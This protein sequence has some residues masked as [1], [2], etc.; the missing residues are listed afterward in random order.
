[1]ADTAKDE[2]KSKRPVSVTWLGDGSDAETNEWNGRTFKKG[3]AVDIDD[4]SMVE[5]AKHNRFYKVAGNA[6]KTIEDNPV[7]AILPGRPDDLPENAAFAPQE[8]LTARR[9]ESIERRD[10]DEENNGPTKPKS[11]RGE[12]RTFAE[13][14]PPKKGERATPDRRKSEH[15]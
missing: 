11:E 14:V 12:S 1:M 15:R 4:E 5:T 9:E 13:R 3:E 10:A 8:V 6:A 7:A 2:A